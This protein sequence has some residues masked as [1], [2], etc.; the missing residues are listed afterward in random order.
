MQILAVISA[1]FSA[2]I[3]G[4]TSAFLSDRTVGKLFSASAQYLEIRELALR[5]L[6]EPGLSSKNLFQR[7]E[8][9]QDKYIAA[10]QLFGELGKR[11]TTG[12]IPDWLER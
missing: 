5:S 8:K 2:L 12:G 4:V 6:V 9:V 1:S 10:V 7:L 11:S 3:S